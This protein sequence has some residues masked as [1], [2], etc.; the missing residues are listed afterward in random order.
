MAHRATGTFEVKIAP[1]E[2]YY[3]DDKTLTRFS[4][5]KQFHG[6]LEATSKGEML[7]AGNPAASAGA[8]A[9]EKVNG[10]LNGR[11]GSF[12]L[13][14]NGTMED[15]TPTG[16][17]IVVTPGSGAGELAGIKGKMQIIIEGGKHSYVFDYTLPEK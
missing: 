9:M 10:R 2:P 14:H 12:V 17:T 8:V 1:L 16:W 15:G 7:S 4:L 11:S 3:K 5:D 6:D 13:Q